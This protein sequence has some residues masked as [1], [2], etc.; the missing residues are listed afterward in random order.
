M[1]NL[2]ANKLQKSKTHRFSALYRSVIQGIYKSCT[3]FSL[4]VF[5][6][7]SKQSKTQFNLVKGTFYCTD[8]AA[9]YLL[10][11]LELDTQ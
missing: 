2:P 1:I 8:T 7:V 6:H 4:Q 10:W 11:T 5:R 9:Q 3:C